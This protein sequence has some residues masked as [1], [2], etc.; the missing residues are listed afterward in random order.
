MTELRRLG[1]PLAGL[2]AARLAR[3]RAGGGRRGGAEEQGRA[4]L[5]AR[6]RRP[7]P[8]GAPATPSPSTTSAATA[9][10]AEQVLATLKGKPVILVAMGPLAAQAGARRCSPTLPIVFCMV[11]DPAKLG[12]VHR[13]PTLTGVAFTDPRQEPAR[14]LPHW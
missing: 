4:G 7:P 1:R 10:T 13:P 6:P 2:S 3:R 5:A 9:P 12:L 14:R 11:Q 8:R